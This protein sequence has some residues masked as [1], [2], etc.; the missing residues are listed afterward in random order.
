[1]ASILTKV[2]RADNVAIHKYQADTE[3]D[4]YAI[5]LQGVP[6]GSTCMVINTSKKYKLNSQ[7]EW[8]AISGTGSGSGSCNLSDS[9]ILEALI[10]AN[11]LHAVADGDGALLTDENGNVLL[12]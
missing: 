1:M 2:G 11:M 12:W 4:M 10:A 6:M 7:G 5:D 3:E 8:I 9:D